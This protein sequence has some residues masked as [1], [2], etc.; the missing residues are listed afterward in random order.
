MNIKTSRRC[1]DKSLRHKILP[2][3]RRH[4]DLATKCYITPGLQLK[5]ITNREGSNFSIFVEKTLLKEI[6]FG[7]LALI[8]R[9]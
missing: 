2:K 5:Y 9:P 1:L 3:T 7:I 4:K 8:A 6:I